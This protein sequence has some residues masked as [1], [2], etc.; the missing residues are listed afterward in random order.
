M[1]RH[2]SFA[3]DELTIDEAAWDMAMLDYDFFLFVELESGQDTLITRSDDG[4]LVVHWLDPE[5]AAG[6]DTAP[7]HERAPAPPPELAVSQAIELLNGSGSPLLFFRNSTSGRAN[8]IYR[9]YDGHYGL[10]TPPTDDSA[11]AP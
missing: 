9:R 1:V 6:I 4:S 8:V 2:K 11:E 7:D 5:G 10:I 3:A